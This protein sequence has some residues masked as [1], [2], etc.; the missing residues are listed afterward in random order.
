MFT[1]LYE[2]IYSE[3]IKNRK[4]AGLKDDA[5]TKELAKKL[6]AAA[7]AKNDTTSGKDGWISGFFKRSS[8][9]TGSAGSDQLTAQV[10]ESISDKLDKHFAVTS[11]AI[12]AIA[13]HSEKIALLE[14]H[15]E[16]N[17]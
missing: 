6:K 13:T 5:P 12:D 9:T 2:R 15:L 7:V 3:Y 14:E 16:L 8:T 11:L 17:K 10:T 1:E 4:A